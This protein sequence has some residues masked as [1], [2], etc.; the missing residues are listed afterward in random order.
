MSSKAEIRKYINVIRRAA[1]LIEAELD[2]DDGTLEELAGVAPAVVPQAPVT[3]TVVAAI[4]PIVTPAINEPDPTHLAARAK[5]IQDLLGIDCWPE[6]VPENLVKPPTDTDQKKRSNSIMDSILDKSLDGL[7]FL[8]FGCGDGFMSQ[9]AKRR[10]ANV[11]VGYDIMLSEKWKNIPEVHFT[12]SS[13]EIEEDFFDVVFLYDVL[14]HA[15]DAEEVMSMIGK[16]VKKTGTIYVRCHPWTSRHATHLFKQGLNKAYMHLFLSWDEI[17]DITKQKPMF[18]RHEKNPIEAYRWWF[19]N[20][21]IVKERK[22]AETVSD[23]FKHPDFKT[24]LANEQNLLDV[25]EFLKLMEIQFV[26]FKLCPKQ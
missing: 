14:D 25:D 4:Q 26:D 5:H 12:T 22:M 20:F 15:I 19:K 10:G 23:F 24:L 18:T 8:D 17:H 6:A 11:V 16:A 7:N 21:K 13:T 1:S 2:R 3:Q 9:E